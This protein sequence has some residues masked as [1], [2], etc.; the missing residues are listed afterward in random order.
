MMF[1][2]FPLFLVLPVLGFIFIARMIRGQMRRRLGPES[3]PPAAREADSVPL[4]AGALEGRL[5]ALAHRLGGTLMVSDVVMGLGLGTREAEA[6]LDRLSDEV[7]VRIVLS[8]EGRIRYEFPEIQDR[9]RGE[10]KR[11]EP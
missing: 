1:P 9:L 10:D 11:L 8:D 2:F 3:V 7:H 6:L 4:G 5:F